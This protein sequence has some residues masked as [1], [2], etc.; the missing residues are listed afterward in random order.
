M[1]EE[2]R[3]LPDGEAQQGERG[4][5]KCATLWGTSFYEVGT[6]YLQGAHC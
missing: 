2:S 6:G 1:R 4:P 3:A 5:A